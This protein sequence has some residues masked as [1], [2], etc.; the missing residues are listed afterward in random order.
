MIKNEEAISILNN[1][2]EVSEDGEEGF[3][4][5]A[6]SVEDTKLQACLLRRLLEIK[7]SGIELQGW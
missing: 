5:A 1:L 3:L 7:H 6:Y 2:I 4:N